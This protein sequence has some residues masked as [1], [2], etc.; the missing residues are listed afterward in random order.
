MNEQRTDALVTEQ[1]KKPVLPPEMPN[2]VLEMLER[3][4]TVQ[5]AKMQRSKEAEPKVKAVLEPLKMKVGEVTAM[6]DIVFAFNRPVSI[7]PAYFG[8]GRLL[9]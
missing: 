6:G 4:V 8:V 1:V 9:S 2:E 5:K 3:Q 7:N